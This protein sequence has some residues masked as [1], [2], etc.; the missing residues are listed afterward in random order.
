MLTD[1][2]DLEGEREGRKGECDGL[3]CQHK[4][5]CTLQT[6]LSFMEV[7]SSGQ[8]ACERYPED[9]TMGLRVN[10]VSLDMQ[11]V[12]EEDKNMIKGT[13]ESRDI[14]TNVDLCAGVGSGEGSREGSVA[15]SSACVRVDSETRLQNGIG[16]VTGGMVGTGKKSRKPQQEEVHS[17]WEKE[18]VS[19]HLLRGHWKHCFAWLDNGVCPQYMVSGICCYVHAYP[20][21]WTEEMIRLYHKTMTYSFPPTM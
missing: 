20:S 7:D 8:N 16:N 21:T 18:Y 9:P 13:V 19:D 10:Q 1:Y 2:D 12:M 5:F 11:L 4:T 15:G 14:R 6:V 17:T 3:C